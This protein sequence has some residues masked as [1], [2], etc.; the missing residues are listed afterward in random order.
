MWLNGGPGCSSLGG[1]FLENG[2]LVVNTDGT[3]GYRDIAYTKVANMVSTLFFFYSQKINE[4]NKIKDLKQT[5]PF[6]LTD[7]FLRS[8]KTK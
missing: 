1:L 3:V 7:T 4:I 5:E 2:P 8:K 6:F